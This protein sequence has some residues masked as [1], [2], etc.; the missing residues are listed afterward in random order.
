MVIISSDSLG[1][2]SSYSTVLI[3]VGYMN[4]FGLRQRKDLTPS[5]LLMGFLDFYGNRFNP[6]MCGISVYQDGYELLSNY[7]GHFISRTACRTRTSWFWIHWTCR[8]TPPETAILPLKY[9]SSSRVPL[10]VLKTSFLCFNYMSKQTH[11]IPLYQINIRLKSPISLC[12]PQYR[13]TLNSTKD[14]WN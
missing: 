9:S 12:F 14:H 10:T 5:K 2:L 1:G 4:Y 11:R 3:L 6:G 7:L 13:A 8:T